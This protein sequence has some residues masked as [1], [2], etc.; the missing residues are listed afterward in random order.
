M[1]LAEIQKAFDTGTPY[2]RAPIDADLNLL[3]RKNAA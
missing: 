2:L 3:S 1:M